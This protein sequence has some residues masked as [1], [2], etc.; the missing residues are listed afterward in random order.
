M[1]IGLILIP[2]AVIL[3]TT[4]LK[5]PWRGYGL[6][7]GAVACGVAQAALLPVI[8]M[9]NWN[10]LTPL[11]EWL[12]FPLWL[13]PFALALLSAA[14][15][16]VAAAALASRA[17]I[18]NRRKRAQFCRLLLLGL[19]GINGLALA[20]DFFT[21][22]VFLELVS[23]SSFI[24]I[25]LDRDRAALEAAFKYLILS[26]VATVM[27]LGSL[28]VMLLAAGA[29]H[30]QAVN[31]A[32][33]MVP[34]SRLLL[35][36]ITAFAC[37]FFIK[38]GVVPFHG[39]L[40]DAYGDAPAPASVY[41]AGIVTKSCGIFTLIRVLLFSGAY[42]EPLMSVLLGLGTLSIVVGA[43]AALTQDD[44]KR[45]LAFSS[46]SQMGYILVGLGAGS[47][48]AVIGALFHIF[49]HAVFK[50]QLF[51][52]AAAVERQ[53]GTR[54]L[55]RL[56]GLEHRMPVTGTTSIIAMLST[57]GI[58][59]L[60]GF[61]SKLFIIAGLWITGN[62]T[63]AFLAILSSVLTLAYFLRLQRRVF[64]GKVAPVCAQV[65][66]AS[67]WLL[68]PACALSAVTI[69]VGVAFPWLVAWIFGVN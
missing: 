55:E 59:P 50:S 40:P 33:G 46:I 64:F 19:I 5:S 61:W 14:G 3:F 2:L 58:P 29:T 42:S 60:G 25:A 51:V 30:Y 67:G 24:L 21:L 49:N 13:D 68:V 20:T 52:N 35:I 63:V 39:W 56:G 23:V 7:F 34:S 31:A 66:E 48:M 8:P 32:F 18:L 62:R 28:A 1:T 36:A 6:W 43:L 16:V 38:G 44:F 9:A 69:G 57:A 4:G 41:L 53:T 26:A 47:P 22:Y 12:R 54:S 27:M 11:N 65:T 17:T 45:V 15:L 37:G 10:G